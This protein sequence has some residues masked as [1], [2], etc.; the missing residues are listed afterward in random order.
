MAKFIAGIEE[1]DD[2]VNDEYGDG[3][4]E[5]EDEHS[6]LAQS[7]PAHLSPFH[8]RPPSKLSTGARWMCEAM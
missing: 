5:Y 2:V 6:P 7:S 1:E 3:D 4:E 8:H